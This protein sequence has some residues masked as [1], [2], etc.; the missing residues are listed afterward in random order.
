MSQLYIGIDRGA[1]PQSLRFQSTTLGTDMELRIDLTKNLN[2]ADRTELIETIR[3][4]LTN[5]PQVGVD[6]FSGWGDS[7]T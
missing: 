7:N 5:P 6:G 4:A 3:Q 2:D 1:Y